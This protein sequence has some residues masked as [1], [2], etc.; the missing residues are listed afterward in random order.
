MPT[1]ELDDH[2]W[3]LGALIA[4]GGFA[5]V[6]EAT[7][8]SGRSAAIKL[9]PKSPGTSRDLLF[10]DLDAA[11]DAPNVVPVFDRGE[12]ETHWAIAMPVAAETLRD[13][14][15][16]GMM[17][18][19]EAKPILLSVL[20]ALSALDGKV[21]HRDLKPDNIF[22]VE[23]EWCL[24]DFGIARYAEAT[25]ASDT[26]KFSMTPPYAAPEQW[27]LE[28]ASA[29]T[30]IYA[31]G[32]V[33]FEMLAGARPFAGP[34]VDDYRDQHLHQAAPPLPTYDAG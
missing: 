29:A 27:R 32:I 19:E 10:S 11:H 12:T 23:G 20:R 7:D 4:S 13:A 25:T 26:Q 34:S 22:L 31:F 33:V 28:R 14:L 5:T 24:G 1:I 15:A 16:E 3:E 30:D 21:V 18:F 9:I 17:P 6:Y 8:E 2:Q